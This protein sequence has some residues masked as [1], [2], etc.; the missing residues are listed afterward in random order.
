MLLAVKFR[1]LE[2]EA[3]PL[4]LLLTE[5]ILSLMVY[6]SV[7]TRVRPVVGER[8]GRGK[9]MEAFWMLLTSFLYVGVRIYFEFVIQ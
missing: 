7:N 4:I 8:L 6:R 2:N 9:A 5:R 3:F 1:Q